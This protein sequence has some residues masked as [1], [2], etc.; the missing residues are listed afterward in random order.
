MIHQLTSSFYE[1][2]TRKFILKA[3]E[4]LKL[5]ATITRVYGQR[6]GKPLWV[7]FEDIE[8][9]V[10]M[11]AIEAQAHGLVDLVAWNKNS[12]DFHKYAI[13]YFLFLPS[14]IEYFIL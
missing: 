8:K 14:L 4:M 6:T 11:S 2:S 13:C 12:R 5:H 7:V 1:A 10:F 9:D 3:E